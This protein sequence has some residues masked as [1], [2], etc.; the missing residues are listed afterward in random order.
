M[1]WEQEEFQELGLW[2]QLVVAER[3]DQCRRFRGGR[4][5]WMVGG[6]LVVENH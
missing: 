3:S 2:K 4:V 5:D 6:C 1:D